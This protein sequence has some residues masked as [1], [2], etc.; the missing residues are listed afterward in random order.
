MLIVIEGCD[1]S[2]KS[3]VAEN[4]AQ[5]LGCGVLSFPNDNGVTGPMIRQY[6]KKGWRIDDLTGPIRSLLPQTDKVLQM[7]ALTFQALQITNR[8]EVMPKLQA[9]TADYTPYHAV[10]LILARYWQSGWV[11]G[12]LD[13][14][15]PKWLRDVHQSMARPTLNILLDLDPQVAMKRRADR[16]GALPPERYEGKSQFV[17]Q[18]VSLYR[19]LWESNA[20]DP[21]WKVVDA[22]QPFETV[23]ASCFDLVD[24][25]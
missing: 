7:S 14:L 1:G 4:M 18:V 23:C 8:M 20:G 19:E 16:D 25:I 17:S 12:Q 21:S 13:G 2:G 11:Y 5:R 24:G 10:D 3:T 22:S 15:D 6:L 9:A